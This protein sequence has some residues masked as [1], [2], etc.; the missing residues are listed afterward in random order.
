MR[1][2]TDKDL[3]G[4]VSRLNRLTNSPLEYFT[5]AADGQRVINIGHYHIDGAYGGVE[6]VRTMN[7]GGGVNTPIGG[8]HMPKRELYER[9]YAYIRGIEDSKEEVVQ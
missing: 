6:L 1:R 2:I 9:I 4:M 5:V 7:T 3:A 8:G